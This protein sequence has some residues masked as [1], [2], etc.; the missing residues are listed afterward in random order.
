MTSNVFKVNSAINF[1]IELAL[2]KISDH[3][4]QKE[5]NILLVDFQS[6]DQCNIVL[7]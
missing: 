5:E 2:R 1:E 4:I 3:W 6:V 7:G